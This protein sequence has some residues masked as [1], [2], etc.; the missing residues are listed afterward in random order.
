MSLPVALAVL[1]AAV[2]H[3]AWNALLRFHGDRLSMVTLLAAFSG[4][5]ALPGAVWLGPPDPAA[6]PW[7]AASLGFHVGYNTFLAIAYDHGELGRIYP[8]ARGTAPLL[9]LIVGALVL[10][11]TVSGWQ[12]G[13]VLTLAGGILLLTFEGGWRLLRRAPR[14]AAYALTTSGFIAGYSLCDGLGARS[15]GD[16]HAYV[17]WLFVL[18]GIPLLAYGLVRRRPQVL[19]AFV[20]NGGTGSIA[21]LLSLGAYW[22]VVWAMT[23]APIAAV[24]ALRESSV[25]FAVLMG[26]AFLGEQLTWLRAASTVAVV[27]GLVL[28]RL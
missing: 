27:A 16:P 22:I 24:A 8:L 21:G 28:L 17:L 13:A 23:L 5:L 19:R 6:W 9:T 1:L 20:T 3:A 7:L 2:L 15:A 12:T 10:G 26:V 11:Q 4:L 18:D 14:G 25:V